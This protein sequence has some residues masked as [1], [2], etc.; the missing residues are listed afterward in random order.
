LI[1]LPIDYEQIQYTNQGIIRYEPKEPNRVYFDRDLV[2]ILL[3]DHCPINLNDKY[4]KLLLGTGPFM[5]FVNCNK[6]MVYNGMEFFVYDG[7]SWLLK[8][9]NSILWVDTITPYWKPKYC[10][11]HRLIYSD[12]NVDYTKFIKEHHKLKIGFMIAK[13]NYKSFKY[14]MKL[15]RV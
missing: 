2:F 1:S 5:A 4:Q 8:N 12:K 6:V 7:G 10:L 9:Y 13:L 14:H 3:F 11:F 15:Y